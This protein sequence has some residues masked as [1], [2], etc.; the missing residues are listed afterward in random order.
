MFNQGIYSKS[1]SSGGSGTLLSET[2]DL[3]FG[4]ERDSAINKILN[5]NV[6]NNNLQA[7]SYIPI[8]SAQTSLDDFKLNGVTVCVENIVDNVSFDIRATAINNASGVYKV[9]YKLIYL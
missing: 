3:D 2:I 4:S 8:A 6:T 7:F 1:A 5:A 9:K